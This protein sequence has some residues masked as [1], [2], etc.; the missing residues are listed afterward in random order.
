MALHLFEDLSYTESFVLRNR[1]IS[2]SVALDELALALHKRFEKVDR[3]V[4][5]RCE[6]CM[7]IDGQKIVPTT[8]VSNTD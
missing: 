5:E 7:A 4:F 3:V 2:D 8:M 1:Q 6:I